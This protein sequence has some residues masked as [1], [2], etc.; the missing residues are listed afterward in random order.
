MSICAVDTAIRK[1]REAVKEWYDAELRY[2]REHHTRYGVIDPI[3][4]ALGWDTADPKV[5][6]P[7]IP[8]PTP[9]GVGWTMPCWGLP[10]LGLSQFPPTGGSTGNSPGVKGGGKQPVRGPSVGVAVTFGK[11]RTRL[12]EV[13]SV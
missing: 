11:A 10:K 13:V 5:C 12:R 4:G 1:I 8:V 2:W 3:T 6:H 9:R 7:D